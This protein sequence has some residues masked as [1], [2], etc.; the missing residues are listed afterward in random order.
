M[1]LV[2]SPLRLSMGGGG[3]DL[4]SYYN[5]R[6]GYLVAAAINKYIYIALHKTY[7]NN[8]IIKYSDT[9]NP[10]KF[11]EIKHPIF[12]ESLKKYTSFEQGLEITS[13]ADIPGGTGLGSSS[14][15]TTALIKGL[16]FL[17]LEE[18]A[19]NELAEAACQIEIDILK[20]PIGKQDQYIASWGGIREF[21]FNKDGTVEN[22]I[23][24]KNAD[25]LIEISNNFLLVY[26][27][28]TRSASK[29]LAE[30]KNKS[31]SSDSN[32]LNNLDEV[33]KLG[34]EFSNLLKQKEFNEYGKLML[35]H[36]KL[37][38]QR[39]PN[40]TS[41]KIDEIFDLG[42]LNGANGGKL[43]GAGG[44]GF[45]LFQTNEPNKLRTKFLNIGLKVVDFNVSP[46]GAEIIKI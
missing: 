13:F 36:W 27:G 40:M 10:K 17:N 34:H 7:N 25:D 33:K 6:G 12:R 30:Q 1:I 18:I 19:Q 45:I 14:S 15:F 28:A 24:Y 32:M 39:S 23:L 16:K 5:K 8:W 3:T 31:E 41:K 44:G 20:E 35:E 29:I 26:T 11:D 4:E 37:K 38:K 9:E 42:I 43:V 22:K 2:R 46:Y 21:F